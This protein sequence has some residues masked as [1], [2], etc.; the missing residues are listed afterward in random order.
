VSLRRLGSR[1]PSG[2]RPEF[3]TGREIPLAG[4]RPGKER[5]QVPPPRTAARPARKAPKGDAGGPPPLSL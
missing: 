3:R 2:L 4:S 1:S 5:G